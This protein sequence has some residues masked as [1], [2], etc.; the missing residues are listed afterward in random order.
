MKN[1][2]QIS[3]ILLVLLS[4][5]S[6]PVL[7]KETQSNGEPFKEIWDELGNVANA[8]QEFRNEVMNKL[9]EIS[10]KIS[11]ID[12]SLDT[13]KNQITGIHDNIND[14]DSGLI[15]L[16]NKIDNID[17]EGVSLKNDTKAQIDDI[18]NKLNNPTFGLEETKH[19]VSI[20]ETETFNSTHGLRALRSAI[21]NISLSGISGQSCPEG[22][23]VT[24]VDK[25]GSV[26][27]KAIKQGAE[28]PII[29]FPDIA[30]NRVNIEIEGVGIFN[31]IYLVT[32]PGLE[33]EIIKGFLNEKPFDNPGLSMEFPI[34]MEY[35]GADVTTFQ[36]W[37]DDFQISGQRRS[38]SMIVKSL[39]GNEAFRWN[40]FE[41]IPVAILPGTDGRTRIILNLLG[42][43]DHPPDNILRIERD[44][45]TPQPLPGGNNPE[46][47]KKVEIEGVDFGANWYPAVEVD[48]T[49]R[50]IILTIDY[51][52]GGGRG[53]NWV[54][55][56]A[57]GTD[58]KRSMS[59][60]DEVNGVETGRM[61]YFEVFP[62]RYQQYNM[63]LDIK[64]KERIW[65]R[66]GYREIG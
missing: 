9:N 63:G 37:Y 12:T 54:K 36:Q 15:A 10:A 21:D 29:T 39:D 32:G 33:I 50:T 51:L 22:S 2:G 62:Y 42:P 46:T 26:I 8:T 65:I 53:W 38:M 11:A 28:L 30:D 61:N 47:D 7:A 45:G 27:C 17:T 43:D 48:E 56:V 14:P 52:E 3:I 66:Y 24:G 40:A 23:F 55:N 64:S 13:V 35:S 34:V 25:N 6:I 41:V 5:L 19:E 57:K 58:H 44:G 49:N 4:I 18:Q 1:T 59:I 20:I 31:N 60:I 16:S